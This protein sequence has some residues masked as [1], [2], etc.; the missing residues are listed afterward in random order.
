MNAKEQLQNVIA[1]TE[2]EIGNLLDDLFCDFELSDIT[3]HLGDLMRDYFSPLDKKEMEMNLTLEHVSNFTYIHSSIITYITKLYEANMRLSSFK[4]E[5][6]QLEYR[7][8][9]KQCA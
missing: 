8:K 4:A 2:K 5:L 3:E 7:E 9:K 6:A 1:E